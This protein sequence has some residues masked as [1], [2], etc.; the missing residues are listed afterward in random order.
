MNTLAIMRVK[1]DFLYSEAVLSPQ[2][3]LNLYEKYAEITGTISLS[4]IKEHMIVDNWMTRKADLQLK[5]TQAL[6]AARQARFLNR[7]LQMDEDVLDA[8]DKI[9]RAANSC[10]DDPARLR[11]SDLE[12]LSNAIS[13]SQ[14]TNNDIINSAVEYNKTSNQLKDTKE[15]AA[16]ISLADLPKEVLLQLLEH[17]K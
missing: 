14:T 12:R 8:N 3:C 15:I 9:I 10:L 17:Q 2:D 5:Q 7:K 11:V 13:K 4:D 6:Y 16:P 1:D